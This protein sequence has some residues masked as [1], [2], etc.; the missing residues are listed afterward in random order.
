MN[1]Y[2]KRF[3]AFSL[4]GAMTLS[5]GLTSVAATSKEE[6]QERIQQLESEKDALESKIAELKE[7]KS[8]TED[9][10]EEL[11][12]QLT[13]VT[14]QI[15]DLN[16]QLDE[17]EV[18]ISDTQDSLEKAKAKENEQYEVL[19]LRIKT[20]YEQG[21]TSI[22]DI[23]LGSQDISTVLNSADYIS[24]LSDFDNRLLESL[25]ESRRTIAAYE[26]ELSA[27]QT[28]L[29]TTKTELEAKQDEITTLTDAKKDELLSLNEDIE[30]AEGDLDDV[31][32]DLA[33]ENN[34]LNSITAAE[35]QAKAN[36]EALKAAMTSSSSSA[37]TAADEA[38]K[39][40]QQQKAEAEAAAAAAAAK[41]AEAERLAAEAAAAEEAA[42]AEAEAAAKEAEAAA[43][44]AAAKAE[45]DKI[46]AEKAAQEAEAKKEAANTSSTSSSLTSGTGSFT[47]PLPGYTT[48]SSS[49]GSRTCP[50]HGLEYHNGVDI[51][52]PGGTSV[53]AADGGVVVQ[54]AYDSSL[55]NYV[56]INHGN[57]YSTWYLHNSSLAVYV[58]QSVSKG[59]V[60][61]Y[62]GTTGSSTGNH[63]DFRVKLDSGGYVN[64]LSVCTPY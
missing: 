12:G 45:Q 29:E 35:A 24:Q 10:I 40:A 54:A 34:I 15:Q 22:L 25:E 55:G 61:S 41:Q 51:P 37:Q 17:L 59:Q 42:R 1:K 19:K 21:E 33:N 14:T 49:F 2:L 32:E 23:L 63:L 8:S 16:A 38:E 18:Q 53:H 48:I 58:G 26:E 64:P 43:A 13:D 31:E 60:I 9:Y 50:Y 28:E 62:V 20:I 56:V 27:A 52:A 11:D 7:N 36:Y 47:W 44:A 6:A 46:A 39:L 5:M 4:I 30:G 3:L 57:G